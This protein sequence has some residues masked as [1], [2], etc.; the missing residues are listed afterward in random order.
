MNITSHEEYG[1]RCALQLARSFSAGSLAAS[2]VAER[3][4]ISV[5]YVSKFMHLFRR[6]GIVKSIRGTQG[7]FQLLRPPSEICLAEILQALSGKRGM[8][9]HFCEQ[10]RGK[11]ENC[12]NISGCSIRPIWGSI[13]LY[14]D[15]LVERMTLAD[16][17]MSEPEV[18]A[19]VEKILLDSIQSGASK[20]QSVFGTAS[21]AERTESPRALEVVS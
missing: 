1:L 5:E 3:E 20:H 12:V 16:L 13:T 18:Q 19:F 15:R 8:E 17:L 14:F 7:G 21:F 4:G 11:K 9:R 6:A 2:K 10:F